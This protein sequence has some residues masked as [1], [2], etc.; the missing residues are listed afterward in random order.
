MAFKPGSDVVRL[1]SSCGQARQRGQRTQPWKA[2]LGV[3]AY[4]YVW[5]G[6]VS[7]AGG[8]RPSDAEPYVVHYLGSWGW[9]GGGV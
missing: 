9:G 8:D 4:L 1:E 7:L 2:S 3:T 5:L 6:A